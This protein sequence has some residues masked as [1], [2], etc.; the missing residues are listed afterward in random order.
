M[1][2]AVKFDIKREVDALL[3]MERSKL[4]VSVSQLSE[5][6]KTEIALCVGRIQKV[7]KQIRNVSVRRDDRVAVA[8]LTIKVESRFYFVYFVQL[9]GTPWR[10]LKALEMRFG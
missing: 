1:Q 5:K 10:L 8:R 2:T 9:T 7:E 3:R 4:P 6:D